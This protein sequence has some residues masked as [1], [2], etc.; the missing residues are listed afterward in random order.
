[1]EKTEPQLDFSPY[2]GI[3]ERWTADKDSLQESIDDHEGNR[4]E[5]GILP[6]NHP[7]RALPNDVAERAH[8]YVFAIVKQYPFQLRYAMALPLWSRFCQTWCETGDEP[9]ALRAI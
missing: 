2:S 6:Y 4:F 9:T 8:N 1:M 5:F 7:K 3:K